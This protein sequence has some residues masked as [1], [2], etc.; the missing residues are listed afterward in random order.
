MNSRFEH[1]LLACVSVPDWVAEIKRWVA[2]G[3]AGNLTLGRL[4]YQ[5]KSKLRYGQWTELWRSGQIPFSKRKGEQLVVIGQNLGSLDAQDAAH[6]PSAWSTL[7]CLAQLECAVFLRLIHEG[8]IHPA[9]SA[10]E[11]RKLLPTHL[12]KSRSPG[13]RCGLARH[14]AKLREFVRATLPRWSSEER[15][16]ALAALRGMIGEIEGPAL[17]FGLN[18]RPQPVVIQPAYENS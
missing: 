5:A 18:N 15:T 14:L 4:L 17:R 2:R 16:A 3:K 13:R 1:E 9:L 6:L 7:Y 12:S 11:A 8:V 10:D